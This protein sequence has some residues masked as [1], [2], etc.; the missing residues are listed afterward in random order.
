M[1]MTAEI[2][3]PDE[4][5]D[6]PEAGRPYPP[7]L[8]V[9]IDDLF[10]TVRASN[11]LKNAWIEYVGDLVQLTEGWLLQFQNCGRKTVDELREKLAELGLSF[12]MTLDRWKRPIPP[13][14]S[15][16]SAPE[17][18][19]TLADLDEQTRTKLYLRPDELGL[20][21]RARNVLK[22]AHIDFV[23]DLVGKTERDLSRLDSCG[24]LT[25]LEITNKLGELG[26][27]LGFSVSDWDA[28]AATTIR[29]EQD[30]DAA[31]PI[32]SL[33]RSLNVI[34]PSDF[35]EDELRSI[36]ASIANVRDTDMALKQLGWSGKGQRTLESVG[37]EYS[38][39]RERVRQIVARK[40]D[41][42]RKEYVETPRLDEALSAIRDRCPARSEE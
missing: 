30:S 1:R 42:I 33:R 21:Q 12:G 10:L 28:D 29:E 35:L 41:E 37:Q 6:D 2:P 27:P 19:T 32:A 17:H 20:S 3:E 8:A 39:T 31:S 11:V 7:D 16:A 9:K 25:R 23:G 5:A 34:P 36:F 15:S 26:V 4:S 38:I 40:T 22:A 14:P 18:T 24:R 13:D